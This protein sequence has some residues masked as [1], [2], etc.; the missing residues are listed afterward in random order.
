MGARGAERWLGASS[1]HYRSVFSPRKPHPHKQARALSSHPL[2]PPLYYTGQ[3][4][5]S[6]A[7]ELRAE[8]PSPATL[9]APGF[10]LLFL[11]EFFTFVNT[12]HAAPRGE[13]GG[14]A[15]PVHTP[16]AF[17]S[18]A[19]PG[20]GPAAPAAASVA[21]Q[22]GAPCPPASRGAR[23]RP[24]GG[25]RGGRECGP[26][27]GP[28]PVPVGAA[29]TRGTRAPGPAV[30][31]RRLFPASPA[32]SPAPAGRGGRVPPAAGR[33]SWAAGSWTPSMGWCARGEDKAPWLPCPSL[34]EPNAP[35]LSFV[36]D[37]PH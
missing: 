23:R 31:H 16:G 30:G 13:A 19:R 21:R 29:E 7:E 32:G 9:T 37:L 33:A 35:L 18:P 3:N 25:G 2:P 28:A 6:A 4:L 5:C 27:S 36:F 20:P 11:T 14:R 1:R 17:G 26:R 24:A 12:R 34:A 8:C 15:F 22:R 10:H